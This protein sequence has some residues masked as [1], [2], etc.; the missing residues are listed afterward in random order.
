MVEPTSHRITLRREDLAN[1]HGGRRGEREGPFGNISSLSRNLMEAME[2]FPE[3][4]TLRV[5]RAEPPRSCSRL[6]TRFGV[7]IFKS[8]T[9]SV[10]I[11]PPLFQE[12]L[13]FITCHSK[14]LMQLE[15][16]PSAFL[17]HVVF[18]TNSDG[19]KSK[20]FPRSTIWRFLGLLKWVPRTLKIW[21][22]FKALGTL[23]VIHRGQ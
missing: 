2:S 10:W 14:I 8:F 12:W 23:L 21:T 17:R 18:I 3:K 1:S 4:A 20:S 5:L 19:D 7:Q 9:D 15:L 16:L 22:H 13:L 6:K 11:P